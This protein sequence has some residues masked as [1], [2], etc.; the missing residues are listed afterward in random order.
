VA[1]VFSFVFVYFELL[2]DHSLLD[3]LKL[4]RQRQFLNFFDLNR[5]YDPIKTKFKFFELYLDFGG[6]LVKGFLD[7]FNLSFNLLQSFLLVFY[8]LHWLIQVVVSGL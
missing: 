1:L 7:L 8:F 5:L 3:L 4:F 2:N 6:F